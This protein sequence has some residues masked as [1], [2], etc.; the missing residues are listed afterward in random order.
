[1]LPRC[2]A[3][4]LLLLALNATAAERSGRPGESR[5]SDSLGD[6]AWGVLDSWVDPV[7]PPELV[8]SNAHAYVRVRFVIDQTGAVTFPEV[9]GRD[10]RF[11]AAA[12][13]AIKQWKFHPAADL[14]K[15]RQASRDVTF[16]FRASGPPKRLSAF[17]CLYPT[18]Q[19]D[20]R[21]PEERR[22]PDPVY[23][24]HLT[25]RLMA[26]EVELSMDVD[27]AGHADGV[28][29]LRATHADFL[30]VAFA[31]VDRWEFEPAARGRVPERGEKKAVLSFTV[32][33]TETEHTNIGEWM[34]KNGIALRDP[35]APKIAEYFDELPA[36]ELFIDPV[37][38][39][40]QLKLGVEGSAKA[41][42]TVNKAGRVIDVA[43]VAASHEDFGAALVTA[44]SSWVFKPLY[45]EKE[46]TLAD[47]TV[48]WKFVPPSQKNTSPESWFALAHADQRVSAKGLDRPLRP[49][50]T[51][52]LPG[53]NTKVSAA[54]QIEVVINQAGR[55]CW[56]R[57]VSAT[58][59][60]CGW[61]AA[62][63]VSQWYFETPMKDGHPVDVKV[64]LPVTFSPN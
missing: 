28:E 12:L 38:P 61:V 55:V 53:A 31:T 22:A 48:E 18:E 5:T 58:D 26:G 15:P 63:T 29:V 2:A 19:S 39:D 27:K 46:K 21:P 36:P 54:A 4:S 20:L 43:L 64:I 30:S 16:E 3:L 23:P 33:D 47:F 59:P 25:N 42:F 49:L 7:Y 1:M 9:L 17:H 24:R 14:A 44:V 11:D 50:Y 34:E 52:P 57:I 32:I 6:A 35:S 13:A 41:S 10:D 60:A 37:Y 62:T 56:P 40:A 45:R 51:P 8:A